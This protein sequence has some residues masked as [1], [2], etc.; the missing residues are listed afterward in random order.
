[1]GPDRVPLLEPLGEVL[2]LQHRL[3]R[4]R[5]QQV[6]DVG[7]GHPL[8]PLGVAPDLGPVAVE[9]PV[10]LVEVGLRVGFDLLPAQHRSGLRAPRRV[11]DPGGVVADD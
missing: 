7:G 6:E 3:Q 4:L 8:Q 2:P 10:G 11:A 5:P 9:N 1:M